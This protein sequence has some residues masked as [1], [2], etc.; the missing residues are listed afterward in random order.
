M[1]NLIGGIGYHPWKRIGFTLQYNVDLTV[2]D[3][4]Y[5]EVRHQVIQLGIDLRLWL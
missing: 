5:I 4:Y 1:A 3:E 2:H